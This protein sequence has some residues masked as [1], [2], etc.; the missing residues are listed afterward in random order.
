MI[1]TVVLEVVPVDGGRDRCVVPAGFTGRGRERRDD[2]VPRDGGAALDRHLR[3]ALV[4]VRRHRQQALDLR[5]VVAVVRLI[6]YT[7][8]KTSKG[9]GTLSFAVSTKAASRTQQRPPARIAGRGH[10]DSV[11]LR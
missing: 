10:Q 3:E 2:A 5:H 9:A 1:R 8:A 4:R 11:L 6:L 7:Y